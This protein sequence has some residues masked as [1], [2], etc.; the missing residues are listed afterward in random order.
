MCGPFCSVPPTGTMT[1]VWPLASAAA[2]SGDV[3][4]SRRTLDAYVA[5]AWHAS[6]T[7]NGS[8]RP[9]LR[10]M[11]RIIGDRPLRRH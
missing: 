10:N 8:A 2:T 3:R 4:S 6:T 1:V 7:K 11:A 5:A 9:S